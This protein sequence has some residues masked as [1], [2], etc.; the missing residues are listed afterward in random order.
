M[1]PVRTSPERV[2]RLRWSGHYFGGRDARK[3]RVQVWILPDHLRIGFAGGEIRK[4]PFAEI[5]QTQGG[6]PGEPARIERGGSY[7]EALV[8]A[9]QG[10]LAALRRKAGGRRFHRALP[11]G[12]RAAAVVAAGA[13]VIALGAAI[14]VWGIPYVASRAGERVP[15]EWERALGKSV[16]DILA[17]EDSRCRN[18]E[19][20]AAI[21]SITRVLVAE[22]AGC[23]YEM[24]VIVSN[25]KMVNAFAA[26]GGYIVLCRGLIERS[27]SAEEVAGVLAHE[28]Q[29]VIHRHSTKRLIA[30][31]ST[32]LLAAAIAGDVSGISAFSIE[33]A[34]TMGMLR[35]SREDEK[36]A[37]AEALGLLARAKVDPAGLIG[38]FE[39]TASKTGPGIEKYEMIMTHPIPRERV[40]ALK[41]LAEESRGP[42]RKLLP[43]ANWERVKKLCGPVE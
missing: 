16:V 41:E 28:M 18:A 6:E 20:N 24:T 33:S 29:H 12:K 36:E 14:Y 17:S 32:G 23:P 34:K 3:H 4:W 25:M 30:Q 26:P 35:Y 7:G 38:F 22:L 11:G 19:L 2:P 21:R 10:F 5:R 43:N 37:D 8:V 42:T 40:E 27:A 39:R 1:A 15:V 13:A 31:A 9:D